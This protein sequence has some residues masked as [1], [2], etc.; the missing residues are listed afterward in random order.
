LTN[1]IA[2]IGPDVGQNFDW[3]SQDLLR[4]APTVKHFRTFGTEDK[5]GD[6]FVIRGAF[7]KVGTTFESDGKFIELKLDVRRPKRRSPEQ[8]RYQRT[9]IA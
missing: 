9:L 2:R 5:P 1:T 4:C 3:I 6:R 7:E 8:F